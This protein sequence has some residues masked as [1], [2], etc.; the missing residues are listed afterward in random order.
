M[1]IYRVF[2]GSDGENHKQHLDNLRR[3]APPASS[4]DTR[5]VCLLGELFC[6]KL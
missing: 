5:V 6:L 1:G 3:K 4:R 2:A